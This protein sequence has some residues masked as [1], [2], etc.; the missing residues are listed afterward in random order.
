MNAMS[1]MAPLSGVAS[2]VGVGE[3]DYA[4]DYAVARE[5]TAARDSYGYAALAFTRALQDAG[6]RKQDIDGLIVGPTLAPERTGE[7]LGMDVR[8]M[9]QGDAVNALMQAAMVIQSGAAECIALVYGNNQRTRGTQYGGA[10]ADGGDRYLAYTYYAPWGMT[11]QGALYALMTQRYMALHGLSSRE[12][13]DIAIAQRRFAQLNENAIMRQPL[14]HDQYLQ[15]RYIC[16][17]LRLYDYCLVNDGGVALIVMSTERAKALGGHAVELAGFGRSDMNID[18]TSLKPRLVDFYHQAHQ[19]AAS[20][21]FNNAGVGPKDISLAQIYDSFS[22]HVLFAL[23]GFGYC[24]LGQA[25]R[26]IADGQIGPGGRLP[27]NTSGG[28]LSESYMQGW[29]HQ[30]ELVR[31]LRG[32]AGA[33]QVQLARWGH[34]MSDI[35]GKVATIIYRRSV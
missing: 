15:A 21:V 19:Q 12:L 16:E 6:L 31:Q 26:F 33:R 11:S 28:H 2:V 35:A 10:Q 13:G 32:Q 34:Y 25:G 8:W 30:V 14:T 3:T 7:V 17:P 1:R 27:V 29:N 22:A 20:D 23:E 18:A 5:K 9:G 4:A 24:E